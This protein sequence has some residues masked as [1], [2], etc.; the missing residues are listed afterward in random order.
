LES[1]N[2]A[3]LHCTF[4][5]SLIDFLHTDLD[6]NPYSNLNPQISS[7]LDHYL[8][9]LLESLS[10]IANKSKTFDQHSLN[11]KCNNQFAKEIVDI[12]LDATKDSLSIFTIF[13]HQRFEKYSTLESTLE[14]VHQFYI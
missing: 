1:N 4:W 6:G 7:K 11:E 10:G 14:I 2:K 13:F 9:R 8:S 3:G 5:N 12:A